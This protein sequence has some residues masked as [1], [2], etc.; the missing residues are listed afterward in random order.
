MTPEMKALSDAIDPYY[1][2]TQKDCLRV[3]TPDEIREKAKLF[4]E[5]SRAQ[6]EQ[7]LRAEGLPV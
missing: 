4:L 1:D 3:D 7:A 6:E 2:F 5:L